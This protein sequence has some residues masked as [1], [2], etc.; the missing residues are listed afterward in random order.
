MAVEVKT[1]SQ[2]AMLKQPLA[3]DRQTLP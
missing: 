3:P 1:M 2:W